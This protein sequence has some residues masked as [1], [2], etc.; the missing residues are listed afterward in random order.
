MC[1]WAHTHTYTHTQHTL[2]TH[3]LSLSLSHTH[4]H[5]QSH[6]RELG[7]YFLFLVG[8]KRD[9]TILVCN[10]PVLKNS[11]SFEWRFVCLLVAEHVKSTR[12]RMA[13]DYSKLV[14]EPMYVHHVVGNIMFSGKLI[15]ASANFGCFMTMGMSG[16]SPVNIPDNFRVCACKLCLKEILQA[17][18][19]GNLA[20]FV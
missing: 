20:S 2:H 9:C 11:R 14:A 10:L 5:T 19:K 15:A 13:P 1:T 3:T 18:F 7:S 17:M 6:S 8:C 4:T 16:A 12:R